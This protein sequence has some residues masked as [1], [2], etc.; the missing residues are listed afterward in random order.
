MPT[1][2]MEL[3]SVPCVSLPIPGADPWYVSE[4]D[5][6][7]S[8]MID[9]RSRSSVTVLENDNIDDALEHLKHTGVRCAFVV[10][11]KKQEV[12]GMLTAHDVLG[13]K[14]QQ[15]SHFCGGDRSD[16]QVKDIM[17]KIGEW[18]VAD[19]WEIERSTVED[20]LNIFNNTGLS[21]LPV[22]ETTADGQRRLRGLFS[23]AKIKRLLAK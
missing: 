1:K 19:I 5:E 8:V 14:P 13:E 18:R 4:G 20:I 12:V 11:Q 9:F 2:E 3:K 7:L 6:A 23:F 22:V 17:Q 10:N 15:H 16:I 21:H